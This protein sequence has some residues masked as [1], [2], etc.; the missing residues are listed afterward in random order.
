MKLHLPVG[1]K[2]LNEYMDESSKL[3]DV[4]QVIKFGIFGINT[5]YS[6][7]LKITSSSKSVEVERVQRGVVRNEE[8]EFEGCLFLGSTFIMSTTRLLRGV[9][10]RTGS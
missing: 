3:W 5:Y 4:C 8:G 9:L 1:D 10:E 2:W 6:V 7:A